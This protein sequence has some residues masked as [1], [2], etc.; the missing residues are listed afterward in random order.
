MPSRA[1][2][3]FTRPRYGE[4]KVDVVIPSLTMTDI[5]PRHNATQSHL[6]VYLFLARGNSDAV[7]SKGLCRTAPISSVS[8]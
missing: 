3:P 4:N 2:R 6:I 1:A 7:Q 5:N 8:T